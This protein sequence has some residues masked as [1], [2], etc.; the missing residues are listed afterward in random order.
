MV[1]ACNEFVGRPD[2]VNNPVIVPPTKLS[3]VYPN[4]VVTSE[5]DRLVP[6]VILPLLSVVTLVYVPGS[7]PVFPNVIDIEVVP[8]PVASPDKLII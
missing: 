7:T 5:V 2:S 8:V 1:A 3:G 4:A 6:N